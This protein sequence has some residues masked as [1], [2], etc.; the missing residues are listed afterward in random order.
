MNTT[1]NYF[2][3]CIH[4]DVTRFLPKD[5]WKISLYMDRITP[6]LGGGERERQWLTESQYSH[7]RT[8]CIGLGKM[9]QTNIHG[10]PRFRSVW[11]LRM[12]WLLVYNIK[13]RWVTILISS[14]SPEA[15]SKHVDIYTIK[16]GTDSQIFL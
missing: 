6:R 3:Q 2:P 9:H 13:I 1:K 15:S 4:G 14:V 5:T 12:L 8:T 7:R 10:K 16:G 11:V